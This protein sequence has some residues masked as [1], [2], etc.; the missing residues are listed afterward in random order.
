MQT[1]DDPPTGTGVETMAPPHRRRRRRI[2]RG[3]IGLTVAVFAFAMLVV[4][5][6]AG[7]SALAVRRDLQHGRDALARGRSALIAGKAP[8]AH[9]EFVRAQDAFGSGADRSRSL[10]LSV[11]GSIPFL[12]NTPDVIRAV[13]DAGVETADAATALAGAVAD[14]PGGLGALAPTKAGI[15]IDRLAGITQAIA[16]ADQLTATALATLESTPTTFLLAPVASA[17][18]DAQRQLGDL[19]RQLHA[20]AL[21]LQG[22]PSFL[23]ADEPRHYFFGASNPAELRGT[24]GLIGAYSILTVDGGSLSFSAFRPVES[25]PR[26]NVA[27]VPSPSPEYSRNWDFYR[28]DAG[29][30]LSIN[31]TPDFPLAANAIWLAYREATGEALD[32]VIVAD[33][34][35]LKALM[36]VTDPIPVGSTGTELTEHTI[37]PFVTN[38]AYAL[39]DTNEQRKLVLGHVAEAVLHGFLRARGSALPRTRA[40]LDAFADGHVQA[41]SVDRAMQQGLALTSVGGA[42]RPS[43]TD[44]LS[45]I[46]N[47]ASGTKLDFYQQRTVTYDV[48]LGPEGTATAS[49]RVD[50]QNDSPTSGYPAY[51]IGPYKTYSTQPGENV[52]VV[53]LYCDTGCVLQG[54]THGGRAVEL[55]RYA[56]EGY[57]FF[58]DYVRTPSGETATITADLLLTQAWTGSDTGGTYRLSFIGQTTIR[59]TQVRVVITPPDGMRFTSSGTGLSREGDRLVYEGSPSGNLDLEATFGPSF[60]VRIWRELIRTIT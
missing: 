56:Q 11:A 60:P 46:T 47:S 33:P 24:G 30:W 5:A 55:G 4:F 10:W 42:F 27:D 39:F 8:E 18:E 31:M 53:D 12:G 14:L 26:L 1:S 44:A 59:P 51:V 16:R 49:L 50:L 40:L 41:W 32:G 52:A 6:L 54:A 45:V 23:G 29:F 58:E 22:L 3:R 48:H 34:F 57:P 20:G 7:I 36:R 9:D 13:A 2:G 17:R 43:G 28:A 38:E 25:L 37:V 15:P 19:H 21:I 35:A